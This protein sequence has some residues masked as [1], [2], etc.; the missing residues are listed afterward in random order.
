MPFLVLKTLFFDLKL[1]QLF[2][3]FHLFRETP[4]RFL[5]DLKP[6]AQ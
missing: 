6:Y 2:Q 4:R 1:F 3:V 5:Q